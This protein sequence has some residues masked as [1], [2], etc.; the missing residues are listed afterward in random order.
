MLSNWFRRMNLQTKF[1]LL[2]LFLLVIVL[3]SF[4]A[5]VHWFVIQP[6]K[7]SSENEQKL[8]THTISNQI[9][10]YIASQNQMSQRILSNKQVFQVLSLSRVPTHYE[11]NVKQIDL[12]MF[13][14]IGPTMNILDMI[15]YDADGQKIAA[16]LEYAD[17]PNTL[18]P[19]LKQMLDS[20]E[21][22]NQSYVLH[23]TAPEVVT[24]NRAIIDQN[25][26]RVLV[27]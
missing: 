27:I 3:C 12:I 17:Q 16:F 19:K 11:G 23:L 7:E 24:F 9:D 21:S 13:Q 20:P 22:R 5:Y 18:D 15:I 25:G 6:L 14:A 1:I 4:L 2:F 26:V 10:E 8:I